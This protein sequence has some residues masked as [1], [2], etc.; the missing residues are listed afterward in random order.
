MRPCAT[1]FSHLF[2]LVQTVLKSLVQ[3]V[4]SGESTLF[5]QPMSPIIQNS[6]LLPVP[7]LVPVRSV[8]VLQTISRTPSCTSAVYQHGL[9]I[10]WT[11]LA[12]SPPHD[13]NS[14]RRLRPAISLG[15]STIHSGV[16]FPTLISIFPSRQTFST[17]STRVSSPTSLTGPQTSSD[18]K[19]LTSVYGLYL[20]SMVHATSRRAYLLFLRFLAASG[21]TWPKSF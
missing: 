4:G 20:L 3:T 17:N 6:V 12:K 19:S 1:F 21:K 18:L 11:L 5:L 8:G 13:P 16:T 2:K 9:L 15:A 10:S 14:G 7:N